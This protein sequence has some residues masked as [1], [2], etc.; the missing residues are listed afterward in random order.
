MNALNELKVEVQKALIARLENMIARVDGMLA[1]HQPQTVP[2]RS[3]EEDFHAAARLSMQ[4]NE[5]MGW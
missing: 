4:M 5:K 3:L 2:V 1:A